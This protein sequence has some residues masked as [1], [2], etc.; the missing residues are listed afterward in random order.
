[1][2]VCVCCAT[3]LLSTKLVEADQASVRERE[4]ERWGVWDYE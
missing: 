4:K 3:P 1:V 2:C